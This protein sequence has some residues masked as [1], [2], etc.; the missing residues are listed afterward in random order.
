MRKRLILIF[1]ILMFCRGVLAEES[2]NFDVPVPPGSKFLDSK[3]LYFG[4]RNVNSTLYA[5]D[6]EVGQISNYY[7]SFFEKE[8]FRKLIDSLDE[9]TNRQTLRFQQNTL[10]V[11]VVIFIKDKQAN[12]AISKYLQLAGEPAIEDTKP[13]VNDTLMQLPTED[14]PGRDYLPR[15][16]QSVRIMS[17]ERD[18]TVTIVY[19]TA[20]SVADVVNFYRQNM[21]D[22]G[23]DILNQSAVGEA[24]Q[25]YMKANGKKDLGIELPFSDGE[26]LGQV[27]NDSYILNFEKGSEK[28][29]TTILPNFTSRERGSMVQ[30]SYHKAE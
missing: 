14:V 26:D 6:E 4:N 25:E 5:S 17:L 12:I 18:K 15:L 24:T 19:T 9:A 30:I 2:M 1:V 28:A 23:W 7:R 27:V 20:L 3:D 11:S 22:D 21:A 13:S 10:V 16:P 8:G 29:E